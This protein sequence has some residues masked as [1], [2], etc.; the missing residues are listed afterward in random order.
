MMRTTGLRTRYI[1]LLFLMVCLAGCAG[2]PLSNLDSAAALSADET[3]VV[4]RIE[5]VPPLE[6]GEQRVESSGLFINPYADK[7]KNGIFLL[8]DEKRRNIGEPSLSDYDNRI[9]AK[10]GKPFYVRAKRAPFYVNAAEIMMSVE[11]YGT[12]KVRL[13]AKFRIDIKPGDKAVYIGTVR[14]HRDEFFE[15]T[16][17]EIIDDYA[18]ERAAFNRKFGN[19]LKLKKSLALSVSRR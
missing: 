18:K 2:A 14:Y 19:G 1:I 10:L 7:M 15:I 17:V 9:E 3:V 4:G 13:P 11:R 5:L 6:E 12:N 16:M 8:T